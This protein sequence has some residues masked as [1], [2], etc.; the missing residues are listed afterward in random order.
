MRASNLQ[1]ELRDQMRLLRDEV[2]DLVQNN[3]KNLRSYVQS[4]DFN[5]LYVSSLDRPFG[6]QSESEVL[7]QIEGMAIAKKNIQA[8]LDSDISEQDLAALKGN[9][10]GISKTKHPSIFNMSGLS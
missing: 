8:L 3:D 5:P 10:W 9:S 4:D 7:E 1:K 2:M 6:A